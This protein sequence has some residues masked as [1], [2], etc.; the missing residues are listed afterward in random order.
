MRTNASEPATYGIG[1][2]TFP[3]SKDGMNGS[4]EWHPSLTTM[5]TLQDASMLCIVT[6]TATTLRTGDHSFPR[7]EAQI[8]EN[9]MSG[10]SWKRSGDANHYAHGH[11]SIHAENMI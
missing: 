8:Y 10:S 5:H 2:Q 11:L 6:Q 3:S 1:T 4:V 7:I 9:R